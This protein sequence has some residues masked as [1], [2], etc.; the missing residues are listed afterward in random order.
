[1][2]I[3]F[4]IDGTLWD[5]RNYIPKSTEDA[6]KRA[7]ANGHK[8]FINTGRAR[9]YVRSEK[10]LSLGFDGIV[11]ACGCMIEYDGRVI[12]NHLVSREDALRTMESIRR[13]GLKPILEGPEHLY[14]D[15][16][17]FKGNMYVEKVMRE[18][19]HSV[20]GITDN[21]GSW[22][23]NKLSCDFR[24]SD[25]ERCF[26]ELSDIY[27]YMVL[28]D[29]DEKVVEMVPK[30]YDKGTGI[31]ALCDLFNKDPKDTMAFGDSVNDREMLEVAGISVAMGR[32]DDKVREI[33][34]HTTDLLERDGISKAMEKYGI[35]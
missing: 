14:I 8:C 10:L 29:H 33:C 21:W 26:G 13:N 18:I 28:D 30:G 24:D 7:R 34:D 2:L 12:L 31:L 3:F 19:G 15:T 20:L 35:I 1:M 32:S 22:R 25:S 16:G 11:S 6:I 4:D 27:T 5:Y 17:D 23:M 9:A